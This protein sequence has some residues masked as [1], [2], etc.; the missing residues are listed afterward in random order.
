FTL[1]TDKDSTIQLHVRNNGAAPLTFTAQTVVPAAPSANARQG[2]TTSAALAPTIAHEFRAAPVSAT[3]AAGGPD[4]F[5]YRWKDSS[6]PGG[7]AY[8]WIEISQTG[9]VV[10]MGGDDVTTNPLPIGFEFPFYGSR[11]TSLRV[12]SN[13]WISFTSS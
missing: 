3:S 6:A 2:R 11:F 7:P 9:T 8:D 12:C 4:V 10:P 5:G 13:G 1:Y